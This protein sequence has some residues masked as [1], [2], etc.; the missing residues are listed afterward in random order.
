MTL[1]IPL[2]HVSGTR[3]GEEAQHKRLCVCFVVHWGQVRVGGSSGPVLTV[4]Q[5]HAMKEATQLCW[6]GGGRAV[7][8][9]RGRS[10]SPREHVPLAQPQGQRMPAGSAASI[11]IPGLK[12]GAQRLLPTAISPSL[13]LS[14]SF[15]LAFPPIAKGARG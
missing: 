6:V 15:G 8:Q 12:V 3:P 7:A 5:P 10:G 11:T 9:D 13:S 1:L 14:F 2:G 4:L